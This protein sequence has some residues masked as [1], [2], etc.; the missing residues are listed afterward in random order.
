MTRYTAWQIHD[1]FAALRFAGYHPLQELC[2]I[3]LATSEQWR[4]NIAQTID[5]LPDFKAEVH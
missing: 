4:A 1:G 2:A 5:A 3:R